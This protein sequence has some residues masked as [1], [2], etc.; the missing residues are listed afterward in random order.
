MVARMVRDHEAMGSNPVTP[1]KA[2]AI[3]KD[4]LRNRLFNIVRDFRDVVA[5]GKAREPIRLTLRLISKIKRLLLNK[6]RHSDQSRCENEKTDFAIG[7]LISFG[8][9]A[10]WSR[11]AKPENPYG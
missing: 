10:T 2:D 5:A 3:S 8:I 9:S 4:R 6:S 11:R 1:T 7:F